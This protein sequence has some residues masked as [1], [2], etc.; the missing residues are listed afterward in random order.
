MRNVVEKTE[1]LNFYKNLAD[2]KA[3]AGSL[4]DALGLYLTVLK[5]DAKNLTAIADVAD[6][7]ADMGLLELSN[8]YWFL[9]LT[10]AAR[11]K[12]SIAYEELAINYFYMDN[13]WASS[14]YFRLK[15]ERDG[16]ISEEGLDEEIIK[17][18]S[19]SDA[20]RDLYYIAYPYDKADYSGIAKIAKRAFSAGDLSRAIKVYRKIPAECRTEEISGDY[21]T[22]LFLAKYDDEAIEVCK[23]S[24][25]RH[26]ENVNAYCNLSSVYAAKGDTDKA[27]HYY[28][29]AL[30]ARKGI[31]AENYK[32]AA[33]A[34]ERGDD[35]TAK[36]S[37]SV[38]LK[39][40]PYDDVMTFFYAI[41]CINLGDYESAKT[42]IETARKINPEDDIYRYYSAL[43]NDICEN[44]SLADEF[45]PLKYVKGL[46]KSTESAIKREIN[47]LVN[48]KLPCSALLDDNVRQHLKYALKFEDRKTAKSAAFLL[49][50]SERQEDKETI[51]AALIDGE[52]DDEVKNALIYL[53][54]VGG[55]KRKINAVIGDCF[56]SVKP[57]K[58]IFENKK[59]AEIYKSAHALAL[60]KTMRW[61]TADS[62]KIAFN[63]NELYTDFAET[64]RFNGFRAED[65]AALCFLM[66]GF[67]PK[68]DVK[69]VCAEFGV[70]KQNVALVGEFYEF[71]KKTKAVKL[72]ERAEKAAKK[73]KNVD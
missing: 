67:S 61:E 45:L 51:F 60:V 25:I 37:I 9:Y 36:N 22:A 29:R 73:E 58:V 4:T 70:D 12:E 15:V 30:G 59:D 14:Y 3:D 55:E 46:P 69:A 20:L 6:C 50:S 68:E 39:E 21:A 40:R 19:S 17:F 47:K 43:F 18:F 57:K 13:L 54:I 64:I 41:A 31:D 7:Y 32:I 71:I 48:G 26:G 24:L 62:A 34:I 65:V 1:S 2:K 38:I 53:L 63:M 44:Y 28:S 49:G 5:A 72:K 8:K 66:C 23:D 10:V 56:C 52:V 27:E 16:F 35:L 11:D 42:M 33:C